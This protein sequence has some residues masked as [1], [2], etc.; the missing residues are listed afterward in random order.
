MAKQSPKLSEAGG[1]NI[2]D[3]WSES[4]RSYLGRSDRQAVDKNLETAT[5][6]VMSG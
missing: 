4:K 5:H 3:G 1:V 2:A 6:A